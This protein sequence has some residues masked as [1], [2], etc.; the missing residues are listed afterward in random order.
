[1]EK[2]SDTTERTRRKNIS[3][4]SFYG[5]RHALYRE[6]GWTCLLVTAG[7]VSHWWRTAAW[8]E[9]LQSIPKR[10]VPDLLAWL[11]DMS[12]DESRF[13]HSGESSSS[14]RKGSDAVP[15]EKKEGRS[16]QS[17]EKRQWSRQPIDVNRATATEWEALS[18]FGPVLSKRTV[19]F[20]NSLG[21]FASLEQLYQVYGLDSSVV[22][23]NGSYFKLDVADVVPMCLDSMSFQSVI[24]HPEFDLEATRRVLRAWGRGASDMGVF[25]KRLQATDVERA[26]WAPYLTI[27]AVDAGVRE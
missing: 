14:E 6:L 11:N 13:R 25:W 20:R 5:T 12:S 1:M 17:V 27:C 22:L 8:E 21:G 15:F 9:R 3:P 26:R 16:T 10:S 24:R 4:A 7:L 23:A 19:S 2:S 18:G